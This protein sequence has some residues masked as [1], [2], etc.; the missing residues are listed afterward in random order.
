MKRNLPYTVLA[1]VLTTT[2]CLALAGLFAGSEGLR[3]AWPATDIVWQIRAPRTVAAWLTGALLGL[4]GALAQGVFRNPLADP[5]LLGAAAGAVLGVLAVLTGGVLMGQGASHWMGTG[6]LSRLGLA[7]G[8]FLGALAAVGLSV[9]FARG[10]RSSTNLLLAGIVVGVLCTALGDLLTIWV[11]QALPGKQAFILGSTA[12]IGWTGN[13]LLTLALLAAGGGALAL[14]RLLDALVLGEEAVRSLGVPLAAARVGLICALALATGAA[15]SQAG[16]IVFVGLIAPH[17]ARRW[18]QARQA[19]TL[20]VTTAVGGALLLAADLA[21]RA[22]IAPQ[23]LP[24]G[25]LTACLGGG[26]FLYLLQRRSP[27]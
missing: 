22:V 4:G 20:L 24:V 15:V 10:G 3:W 13:G 9:L 6:L 19:P 1:V 11:P 27:V 16:L 25:V 23:E 12:F 14:A 5:Y 7:G 8:A 17:I 2:A 21:A 18:V 26:Y